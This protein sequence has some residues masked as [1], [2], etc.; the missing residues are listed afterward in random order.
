MSGLL[1]MS[2]CVMLHY[3]LPVRL[4]TAS[5]LSAARNKSMRYTVH[6]QQRMY[7]NTT[8]HH[9]CRMLLPQQIKSCTLK[10]ATNSNSNSY[11]SGRHSESA[12]RKVVLDHTDGGLA[13]YGSR[14]R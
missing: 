3:G 11:S 9:Y 5:V 14:R 10:A 7:T 1:P 8:S 2:Y 13:A 4:K 12:G 6:I